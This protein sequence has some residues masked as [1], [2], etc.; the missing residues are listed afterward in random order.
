M[1]PPAISIFEKT[2]GRGPSTWFILDGTTGQDTGGTRHKHNRGGGQHGHLNRRPP[3]SHMVGA[4]ASE[5]SEPEEEQSQGH[6]TTATELLHCD[7]SGSNSVKPHDCHESDF[8]TDINDTN[9]KRRVN[10]PQIAQPNTSFPTCASLGRYPQVSRVQLL[11]SSVSAMLKEQQT[12]A[13]VAVGCKSSE[14]LPPYH[15][16]IANFSRAEG[17]AETGASRRR[18]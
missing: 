6:R 5:M 16:T 2:G 17:T 18:V 13:R 4:W 12:S 8:S 11:Q 7:S 9:K 3:G 15:P 14:F 1:R 10:P